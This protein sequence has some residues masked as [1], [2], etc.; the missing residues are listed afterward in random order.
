MKLIV[1]IRELFFATVFSYLEL[2]KQ[3]DNDV[4]CKSAS[5]DEKVPLVEVEVDGLHVVLAAEIW[6]AENGR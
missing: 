3:V 6:F 4:H 1:E 2:T 5:R